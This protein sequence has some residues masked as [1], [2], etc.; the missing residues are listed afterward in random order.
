MPKNIEGDKLDKPAKPVKNDRFVT[1]EMEIFEVRMDAKMALE[2]SLSNSKIIN[3]LASN[4]DSDTR[5]FVISDLQAERLATMQLVAEQLR[6]DYLT[7]L[8]ERS[9]H[10]VNVQLLQADLESQSLDITDRRLA[11]VSKA[12]LRKNRGNVT[13]AV[14]PTSVAV[15]LGVKTT[16]VVSS[17][18]NAMVASGSVIESS[19][20]VPQISVT[21]EMTS[22]DTTNGATEGGA[23]IDGE[24][25][26]EPP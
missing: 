12:L 6:K 16:G 26:E 21:A 5:E 25:A 20:V 11:K 1:A 18:M 3:L 9:Q 7:R 22:I 4:V 17:W 15:S 23:V 14:T 19:A 8:S 24:V 10:V 13:E 2:I